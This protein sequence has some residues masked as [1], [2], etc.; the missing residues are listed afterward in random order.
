MAP[1]PWWAQLTIWVVVNAV[2]LL[3]AVGF[4]SRRGHG[5]AVNHV[6]GLVL[7]ALAVPA[8]VAGVGLALGGSWWWLGP[9]AYV[10]FV[11]LM[12]VVDYV[13]PVEFRSPRRPAILVPYLVAFFG[14]IVLMGIPMFAVNRALWAVTA[15]TATALVA[16]MAVAAR[17]GDA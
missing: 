17:R 6:L 7:A 13:R 3:Q 8:V 14:A 15:V 1:G 10:A 5:M 4:L 16:S 12:L 9:A 11:G 2:C